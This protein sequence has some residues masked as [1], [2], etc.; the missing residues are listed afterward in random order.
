[1]IYLDNNAT[2]QTKPSVVEAMIPY[3]SDLYFNPASVAGE[4]FG[5][6][7]PIHGAKQALASTLGGTPNEF[8]LTSGATESNNWVLQS[9]IARKL[10][11]TGECHV[12]VSAVEHQSVLESAETLRQWTPGL[13]VGLIP[14]DENGIVRTDALNALVTEKT[15]MVSIM[16]ANNETGVIQP[17]GEAARIT[18]RINPE[19]L[20]HTDATQAVGKIP[21][22]LNGDLGEV[23][24]LSLSAHKFHGPKGIG[25]LFARSGSPLDSWFHGGSQQNGMRAGT[26]NPALSAGLAEAITLIGGNQGIIE[27]GRRISALRNLLETELVRR[28]PRI[29]VLCAPSSRLPNTSLLLFPE[30]EGEMLVHLLLEAGIVTS[31][32]SA[33]S[34]GNDHPSH[35]VMA[36]GVPYS[37]ARNSLRISLSFETT[38]DDIET[39]LNALANMT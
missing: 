38:P 36:M 17:V 22:D 37:K 34:Q 10:R 8:F 15:A 26:E 12:I 14:V 2:T 4:L 16:L 6:S 35:V 29:K 25:A 28:N 27:R 9:T 3:W 30:I 21:I 23:D 13:T 32:G 11:E 20:S 5:A 19:C 39:C 31:T 18:K 7:L 33:C 24:F 1:M